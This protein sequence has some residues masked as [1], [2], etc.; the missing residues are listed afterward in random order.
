[1]PDIWHGERGRDDTIVM[2]EQ[3]NLRRDAS[4]ESFDRNI[5]A[6][7][8]FVEE[9]CMIGVLLLSLQGVTQKI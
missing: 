4:R 8:F 3:V 2:I 7:L 9:I 5:K 6:L 1:M